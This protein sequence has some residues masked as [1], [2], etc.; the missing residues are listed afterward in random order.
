MDEI[1]DLLPSEVKNSS[2]FSKKLKKKKWIPQK[3]LYKLC[4]AYIKKL[5][6]FDFS[7]TFPRLVVVF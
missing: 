4:Q 6:I 5:I 1:W 3:Y 7:Q 2:K